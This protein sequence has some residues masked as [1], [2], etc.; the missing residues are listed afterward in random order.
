[1]S[2]KI[3]A[4]EEANE[5]LHASLDNVRAESALRGARLEAT[6]RW[7]QSVTAGRV[8]RLYSSDLD[9]WAILRLTAPYSDTLSQP[10]PAGKP[11]GAPRDWF[12]SEG[13]AN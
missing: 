8:G 10:T 6:H 1:M 7:L 9:L 4:L 2:K 5:A 11:I 13:D 12:T 3:K